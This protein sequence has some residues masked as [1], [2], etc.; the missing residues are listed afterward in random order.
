MVPKL[1]KAYLITNLGR[2]TSGV[3]LHFFYISFLGLGLF[4]SHLK[5]E[6]QE[7]SIKQGK[8]NEV[9]GYTHAIDSLKGVLITLGTALGAVML[10]WG[11][12]RFALSFRQMD[13]AGEHQAIYTVIAGGVLM[14]LG[15][16]VA[17]LT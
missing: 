2:I 5:V 9:M 3:F 15:A 13:S 6:G 17:I 11:G 16:L 7:S 1:N 10:V 8:E 12:I 4:S 14:A